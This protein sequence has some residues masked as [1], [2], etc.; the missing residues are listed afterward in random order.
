MYRF[1]LAKVLANAIE[2]SKIHP[3]RE[4]LSKDDA[5]AMAKAWLKDNPARIFQE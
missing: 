5:L 4:A 2:E 1:C 3:N